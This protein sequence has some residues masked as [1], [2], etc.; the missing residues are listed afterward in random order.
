MEE[1]FGRL[2]LS[3]FFGQFGRGN[4][5]VFKDATFSYNRLKFSFGSSLNSWAGLFLDMDHS[6][7]RIFLCILQFLV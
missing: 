6:I 7:V 1:K 5:I 4:K 2:L 3:I